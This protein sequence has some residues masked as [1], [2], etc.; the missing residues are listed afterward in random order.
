M[1]I[2]VLIKT[3]GRPTLQNAI[4]SAIREGFN[5]IV[6]VSDGFEVNVSNAI[7]VKLPK[8][9]G[10]Y[11]SVAANVGVA[12]CN[13]NYIMLLDDDDELSIGS[14]DIIRNKVISNTD[15]DIW[16]PGLLFNNGLIVCDGSSKDIKPGNVAVPIYKTKV[17]TEIPFR[18]TIPKHFI[19]ELRLHIK[20][21]IKIEDYIDYTHIFESYKAGFSID[22]IGAPTYLVRPNL[23]GANGRGK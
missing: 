7:Y 13:N 3:I 18:S 5:N 4:N 11:G 15:I 16:I 9:W 6:V 8:Q 12:F 23:D 22:W 21:S 17:L 1:E 14:G 20:D 19:K 10:N 2:S